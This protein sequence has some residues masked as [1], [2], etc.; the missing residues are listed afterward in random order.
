MKAGEKK[1]MDKGVKTAACKGELNGWDLKGSFS[2]DSLGRFDCYDPELIKKSGLFPTL[3]RA[4]GTT[5]EEACKNAHN[6]AGNEA[7]DTTC[8]CKAGGRGQICQVTSFSE[9]LPISASVKQSAKQYI[10]EQ[11]NCVPD[12]TD[13]FL[14]RQNKKGSNGG[15]GLRD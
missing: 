9:R 6:L 1:S 7:R 11:S 12:D 14:A 5:E 15:S 2:S 8:I 13:C 4:S 10:R 3:S